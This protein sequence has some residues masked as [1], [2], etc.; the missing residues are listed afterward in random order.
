MHAQA[1][2]GS[3]LP[4]GVTPAMVKEG[5]TLFRGA[6]MCAVCHGQDGKGG[7]GANLTDSL[8]LH[9]K[10]SF[11]EIVHQI[12][13]GVPAHQS[14]NGVPMPAKGGSAITDKQIKAVAAYVWTLSHPPAQ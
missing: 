6:G 9:S 7:I 8:W 1:P 3:I 11:D 5:D 14:K 13:A 12:T 4:E 10:G 2:A